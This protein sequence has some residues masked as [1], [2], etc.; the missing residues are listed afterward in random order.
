MG[1]FFAAVILL[2]VTPGPGVLSVAG[3]GAAFGSRAGLRFVLGVFLGTNAVAFLAASGLAAVV[4]AEPSLRFALTAVSAGY[5][6]WLALRIAMQSDR[7]ALVE[8]RRPPGV[9]GGVALQLVN[10]KCYAVNLSL[11]SGFPLAGLG[12]GEEIAVKFALINAVWAPVHF[13]WL[14]GGAALARLDLGPRA[15][16]VLNLTMA[17]TM[18]AAVALSLMAA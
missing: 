14:A 2:T 6:G 15:R 9:I 17:A 12:V 5:L 16:R 8:H 13:G 3:V 11:F 7:I 4:L 10:P 18:L 1:S